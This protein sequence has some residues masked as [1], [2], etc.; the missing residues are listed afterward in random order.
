MCSF[1]HLCWFQSHYGAIATSPF[2][3]SLPHLS[4]VS[5][6]LWCDCDFFIIEVRIFSSEGFNPT[7]VRLR[8]LH[9]NTSILLCAQFQ[10]HYGAIAT[11]WWECER[12]RW[13]DF[14]PTMV[15]LR[16]SCNISCRSMVGQFQSHYGAIATPPFL[17]F[18]FRQFQSHY[19][20]IATF[21]QEA[22]LLMLL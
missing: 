6:P 2:R 12:L 15:R 14:N 8:R 3:L 18:L 22:R 7:M 17:P 16:Q 11:W 19:G 21:L 20:A 1:S 13:I 10:S 4:L 9:P 5:I